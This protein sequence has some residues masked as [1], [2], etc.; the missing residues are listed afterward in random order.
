MSRI[1]F[2]CQFKS[3]D[4]EGVFHGCA[5]AYYR[6]DDSSYNDV[7][8]PGAFDKGLPS[9]LEKGFIGGLNHDWN[10]P[11]GRP[12][13]VHSSREGLMF[14][15]KISDTAKGRDARTLMRDGVIKT[16]SVGFRVNPGGA[17]HHNADSMNSCWA[18]WGYTPTE[19]DLAKAQ[20]G[21]RVV[22]SAQL[23]EISPV[24]I[25]AN[26]GAVIMGVKGQGKASTTLA[27]HSD[28]VLDQLAEYLGRVE[29]VRSLRKSEGRELSCGYISV[30]QKHHDLISKILESLKRV[31]CDQDDEGL[32]LE[33]ESLA[34]MVRHLGVPL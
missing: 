14:T 20:K 11:I 21:C 33:A 31:H 13:D 34:N 26:K 10:E 22:R 3:G 18:G 4:E 15:A 29:H 7:I 1:T 2:P 8:A 9:F 12:T 6:V 32:K 23:Y 16:V 28:G 17:D 19:D 25:P 30:F 27:E 24:T 5:S